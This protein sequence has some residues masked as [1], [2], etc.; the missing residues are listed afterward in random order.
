MHSHQRD[1]RYSRKYPTPT[2]ATA[3]R[4]Q[5]R[6]FFGGSRGQTSVRHMLEYAVASSRAGVDIVLG[7]INAGAGDQLDHLRRG[8][9]HLSNSDKAQID[10]A[11]AISRKPSILL[12]DTRPPTLFDTSRGSLNSRNF[13]CWRD[14]DTI[15]EAGIHV[16]A[17]VDTSGF[18]SW[19]SVGP[20]LPAR[21]TGESLL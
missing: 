7:R 1:R 5:L 12:I 18:S 11:A 20:G 14:I 3:R 6:F 2:P 10:V 16:W 8:F 4:G 21:V 13:D 9:E 15:V 17:A 19:S